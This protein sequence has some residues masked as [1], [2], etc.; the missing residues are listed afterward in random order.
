MIASD[1]FTTGDLAL[2]KGEWVTLL[3]APYGGDWWRGQAMA[4]EGWFPKSHVEY[5]DREAERKK[6]EEGLSSYVTLWLSRVEHIRF[7][8]TDNFKLAAAAIVAASSSFN[9]R[10]GSL[11]TSKMRGTHSPSNN[12]KRSTT[13]ISKAHINS[14][15][16]M[17]AKFDVSSAVDSVVIENER[18]MSVS[19]ASTSRPNTPH[20][21]GGS[22]V[23]A[24]H[25]TMD[26]GNSQGSSDV[27]AGVK[28]EPYLAKY[29]YVGGTEIE[30]PLHKGEIVSV[31]EKASSGWW[32]GVCGGR[33]GWFPASYVKPAA[34]ERREEQGGERERSM[35]PLDM[36]ES[37]RSETLDATGETDS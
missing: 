28:L 25:A 15:P 24:N 2:E 5:V 14:T 9:K 30:L 21:L 12:R 34:M 17:T 10:H 4:G 20:S 37:L 23:I 32:Q 19:T 27:E 11:S 22:D 1:A 16:V 3:E 8:S 7:P 33:V 29:N 13:T 31:I 35:P 36:E 6:A 26:T 18:H